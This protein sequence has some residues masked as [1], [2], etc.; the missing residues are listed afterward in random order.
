MVKICKDMQTN[1]N[2]KG[3]KLP[4]M[5]M[6]PFRQIGVLEDVT[7]LNVL[8]DMIKFREISL[9]SKLHQDQADLKKSGVSGYDILMRETSD[10]MQDL[11]HIYGERHTLEYCIKRLNGL[12]NQE[13]KELLTKVFRLF[14]AEIINRDLSF[15]QIQGIISAKA[16]ENLTKTRHALIK[17]IAPRAGDLMDCM[18]IPKHALYAPIAQDYVKYNA[19]PNHGEIIGAKM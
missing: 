4:Q 13:N 1:I 6:C 17:D 8:L 10:V 15:F 18:S 9:F 7:T 14:G 2:K 3:H 16:V 12:K 19:H 5:T 11:A